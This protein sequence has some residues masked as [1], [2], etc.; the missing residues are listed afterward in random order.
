M[1]PTVKYISSRLAVLTL[2]LCRRKL[3]VFSIYSPTGATTSSDDQEISVVMDQVKQT[4]TNFPLRDITI[5]A[6]DFNATLSIPTARVRIPVGDENGNSE[7]LHDLLDECD[8]IPLNADFMK[9]QP[10]SAVQ[11]HQI[12]LLGRTLALEKRDNEL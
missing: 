11:E 5:M 12:R 10:R 1:C 3:H 2:Q 6:G 7:F 9:R 4:F 8:L